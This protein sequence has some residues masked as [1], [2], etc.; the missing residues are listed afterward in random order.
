LL[1]WYPQTARLLPWRENPTPYRV[2]IS[3]IMLQ[4]TR[5]QAVLPY[6]NRF[7]NTLPDIQSL[8]RVEED[9]LLKLW[10]GLGYY[11]RARNLKKCAILLMEKHEGTLP[12]NFNSLLNLPGIGRYTAGAILSIAYNEPYPAVDGNVLRILT[13]LLAL[14]TPIDGDP[15][16]RSIEELLKAEYTRE[17]A[18][19]LTQ[20]L[21]ELGA[22]VCGPNQAPQCGNCPWEALCLA[23]KE[24]REEAFPVRAEKK[25][26]RVEKRTILLIRDGERILLQKRPKKG[27]LAGLYEFPGETGF[28]KEKEALSVVEAMG[29]TPLHI[30]PAPKAKHLFSHVEW[31]MMGYLIRTAEMETAPEGKLLVELSQAGREFAIP[32]ALRAYAEFLGIKRGNR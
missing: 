11:N 26:R 9:R 31:E 23:H 12:R 22:V 4:Q 5:V 16:K 8:A 29:F 15:F 30:E 14:D 21:M 1:T 6:F 20:A 25:P 28:L 3:E 32:S 27:L 2:W 18:S 13:R 19:D 24:G 10:E 17:N 7:M